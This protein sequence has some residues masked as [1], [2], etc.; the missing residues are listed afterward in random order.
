MGNT[1]SVKID[2]NVLKGVR[3]IAVK[4]NM[5]AKKLIENAIHEYLSKPA[6]KEKPSK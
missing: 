5:T 3:I 1:S 4:R 2:S 6:L